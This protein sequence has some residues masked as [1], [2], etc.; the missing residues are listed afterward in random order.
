MADINIETILS[1]EERE[2][3]NKLLT[4]FVLEKIE[5]AR[6]LGFREERKEIKRTKSLS[7]LSRV[8]AEHIDDFIFEFAKINK[9]DLDKVDYKSIVIISEKI[10]DYGLYSIVIPYCNNVSKTD[11]CNIT[12]GIKNAFENNALALINSDTQVGYLKREKQRIVGMIEV[13]ADYID[14]WE[15][16]KDLFSSRKYKCKTD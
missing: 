10:K 8:Y 11:A 12:L 15:M 6:K 9:V 16:Y 2:A 4:K 7:Y 14:R 3:A 5:S 13:S 1:Q